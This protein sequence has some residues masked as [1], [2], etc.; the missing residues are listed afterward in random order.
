MPGNFQLTSGFNVD[1]TIPGFGA[2]VKGDDNDD[3]SISGK[4]IIVATRHII[5]NNKHETLIEIVT[6]STKRKPSVSNPKQ[7]EVLV[8]V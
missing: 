6:D 1:L 3:T 5:T 4:Y 2:K 8:A 7:N